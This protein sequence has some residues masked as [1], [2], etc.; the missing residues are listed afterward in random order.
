MTVTASTVEPPSPAAST[1]RSAP[2]DRAGCR[3]GWPTPTHPARAVTTAG[4]PPPAAAPDADRPATLR[5]RRRRPDPPPGRGRA[6]LPGP[7]RR[8]RR[9]GRRAGQRRRRTR[10][11]TARA[12][13]RGAARRVP[14]L[15]TH[16]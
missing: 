15:G 7:P 6:V 4:W 14:V 12:G 8:A 11:R 16:G 10:R 2:G 5:G 1:A 13:L 9:T 3:Y